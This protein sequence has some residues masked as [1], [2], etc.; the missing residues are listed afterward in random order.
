MP[1][2]AGPL[3]LKHSSHK[4]SFPRHKVAEAA[5]PSADVK[6]VWSYTF[7][8]LLSLHGTILNLAQGHFYLNYFKKI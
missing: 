4:T 2:Y 6:K 7:I 1:P 8:T 3:A 5:P